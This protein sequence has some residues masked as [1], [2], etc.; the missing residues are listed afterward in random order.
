MCFGMYHTLEMSNAELITEFRSQWDGSSQCCRINNLCMRDSQGFTISLSVNARD[1]FRKPLPM[2]CIPSATA[3]KCTGVYIARG[4]ENLLH[5]VQ[6]VR[7][8]VLAVR[9]M[10]PLT[11]IRDQLCLQGGIIQALHR[12][13][14]RAYRRP[15]SLQL[16][17]HNALQLLNKELISKF[18]YQSDNGSQSCSTHNFCMGNVQVLTI[19]WNQNT[20]HG[21][22]KPP[23]MRLVHSTA[24]KLNKRLVPRHVAVKAMNDSNA[25]ECCCNY[26]MRARQGDL[27][28]III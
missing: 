26:G 15:I 1:C 8:Q 7:I 9:H 20:W 6:Q 12:G 2:R 21:R 23:P 4:T 5:I 25:L 17:T 16:S 19:A 24:I 28:A 10:H 27:A 11:V 18:G 22:R 3:G 13:S 14:V